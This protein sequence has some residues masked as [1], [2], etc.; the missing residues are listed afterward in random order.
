[1]QAA[2][3]LRP[4]R[5]VK[6]GSRFNVAHADSTVTLRQTLTGSTVFWTPETETLDSSAHLDQEG[7]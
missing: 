4:H 2:S 6:V 5:T 7:R 1:M 3:D